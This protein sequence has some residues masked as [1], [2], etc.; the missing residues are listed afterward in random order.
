[1]FNQNLNQKNSSPRS[2][3]PKLK[4]TIA[5][6]DPFVIKSPPKPIK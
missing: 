1:M 5:S 4:V 3:S 6:K 2:R